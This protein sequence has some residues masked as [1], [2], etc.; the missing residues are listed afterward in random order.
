M[1]Y[2]ETRTGART[3]TRHRGKYRGPDGKAKSGPWVKSKREA[4]KWGQDEEA[5]IRNGTWHDASKGKMTL[6]RYF[7]EQWIPNRRQ[8]INTR[9]F[10]EQMYRAGMEESL[11]SMELRK[12]TQPVIERWVTAM[13]NDGVGSRTLEARF[14]ALQ[15]IIAGESGVSAIRDGLVKENPCA[16]VELPPGDEREVKIYSVQ[17]SAALCE[18]LGRWWAPLPM[19][20]TETGLRWGE[21]MGLTVGSFDLTGNVPEVVVKRTIIEVSKKETNNGTPW[22]WKDR[23]KGRRS[24]RVALSPDAVALVKALIRDRRLFS[25]DDRLFAPQSRKGDGLPMR[26]DEWPEGRPVYRG[27]FRDYWW[28]AHEETGIER[29]GRSFHKLRGSHLTWLL[30]GGAD[31]AT[32]QQRADHRNIS[33][34]QVYLAALEDADTRA[35]DALAATKK[36]YAG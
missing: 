32:V 15:T 24:R 19:L 22:M 20:A 1:A 13:V 8:E 10:Y 36:R 16:G 12:I 5:K 3:G 26:T 9:R 35:L 29:N 6:D 25:D 30:A 33:T 27:T 11:G 21:L 7:T 2:T 31:L 4:L 28:A 18:A 23:P 14:K 17:E 34:T